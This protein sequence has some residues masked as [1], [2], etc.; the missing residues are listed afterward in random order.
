MKTVLILRHA[1]SDWG[2]AGQADFD[3]PLAK[4]GLED[5]PR[6]GEVLIRFACVP[7]KILS[8]PAQRAKQTAELVAKA[9]GYHKAIQWESPFYEGDSPDLIAALQQLSP[10]VERVLLIGHN[11]VL[12]DTVAALC[13]V[14]G[15]EG[16]GWAIKIPTAGLVCLNFEITDWAELQPGDGVL[17]WFI[18]PKLV[19]ALA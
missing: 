11:P 17:H 4:R 13:A 15:A 19:K 5:A 7:D 3:R 2:T 10:T 16:E 9:C 12:E 6:M 14:E 1:K 18:I 8:S